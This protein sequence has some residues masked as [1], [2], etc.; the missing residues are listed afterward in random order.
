MKLAATLTKVSKAQS[1][2]INPIAGFYRGWG[3]QAVPS[4]DCFDVEFLDPWFFTW[5]SYGRMGSTDEVKAWVMRFVDEG[6]FALS[7]DG[8]SYSR[9]TECEGSQ[10][11]ETLSE[12]G[13]S[14]TS[15]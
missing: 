6:E 3:F 12:S 5:I 2:E 15:I 11:L 4:G 9:L 8:Q 10:F 13:L 1:V 7:E 14:I